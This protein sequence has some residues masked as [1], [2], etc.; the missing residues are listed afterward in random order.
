MSYGRG[1][2]EGELFG[3]I[4]VWSVL[5]PAG[6]TQGGAIK[7]FQDRTVEKLQA[8]AQGVAQRT[9]EELQATVAE[10]YQEGS[11]ELLSTLQYRVEA[12]RDG[13]EVAFLAGT[14][15]LVFLTALAGQEKP[16]PGHWITKHGAGKLRFFWKNPP[17]GMGGP[18]VYG[19]KTVDW[20]P[21]RTGGT[22]VIA[23]VLGM[24]Q[25]Q[26]ERVMLDTHQRAVLEFIQQNAAPATRSSR[27]SISTENIISPQY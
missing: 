21:R 1:P 26:F 9:F 7:Q 10:Y 16:S 25:A 15:H 4:G 17:S 2:V 20:R 12:T 27:V 14:D 19:F 18:G 22:D 8:A 24:G 5:P 11:G 13:V 6:L 23:E 3:P